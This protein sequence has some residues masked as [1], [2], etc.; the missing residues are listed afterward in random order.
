MP[1]LKCEACSVR[2]QRAGHVRGLVD[3]CPVCGRPLEAVRDLAEIVGFRSFQPPGVSPPTGYQRLADS[4]AA[5]KARRRAM[6]RHAR[7][8]ADRWAP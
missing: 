5:I 1:H 6:E 2:V 3:P 8:D 4:V 7:F